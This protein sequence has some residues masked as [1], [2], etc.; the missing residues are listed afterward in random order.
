MVRLHSF[1]KPVF[2]R[3]LALFLALFFALL[4]AAPSGCRPPGG[5]VAPDVIPAYSAIR[6]RSET[7]AEL[8]A[9]RGGGLV[10]VPV[11]VD[12]REHAFVLDTGCAASIVDDSFAKQLSRRKGGYLTTTPGGVMEM[13]ICEAPRAS[14]GGIAVPG[15]LDWV[16]CSDLSNLRSI[17]GREVSGILGM[18]FL[19]H[20]VVR[21]DFARRKV[22]FLS[23]D[24]HEH[25]EW[26]EALPIRLRLGCPQVSATVAD[27]GRHWFL[28]D[29]GAAGGGTLPERL[30]RK[31]IAAPAAA[32]LSVVGGS[33]ES[34]TGLLSALTLGERRHEGLAFCEGNSA[35]LGLGL[36]SRYTVTL[37]F[38]ARRLY[39]QSDGAAN[40]RQ[41]TGAGA[42]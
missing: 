33:V 38:P 22:E 19:Q 12:G 21:L 8:P 41:K 6:P 13:P 11:S 16:A 31:V 42:A 34:R 14:V 28:V 10:L 29:T 18:D 40:A 26:G 30:F 37:D 36:F 17:C 2:A 9:S 3:P 27:A 25:P 32:C 4:C 20:F 24:G 35:L 15:K 7:L 23:S 39:L 5:A 1:P